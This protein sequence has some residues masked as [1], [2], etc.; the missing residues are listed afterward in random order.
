[1]LVST[2]GSTFTKHGTWTTP[3]T[4]NESSG[5]GTGIVATTYNFETPIK[6]K[7]FKIVALSYSSDT[8]PSTTY[9]AMYKIQAF[10]YK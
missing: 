3:L 2:D 9:F 7:A 8:W 6:I 1:M 10:G 4:W 5:K